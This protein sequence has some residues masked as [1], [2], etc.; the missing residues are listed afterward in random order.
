VVATTLSLGFFLATVFLATVFLATVFLAIVF[1]VDFDFVSV[2][3]LQ[4]LLILVFLGWRKYQIEGIFTS[5]FLIYLRFC[6]IYH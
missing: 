5:F 6:H 4:A 2:V 3:F 1:L